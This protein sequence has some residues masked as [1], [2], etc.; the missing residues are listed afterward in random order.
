MKESIAVDQ[1]RSVDYH[2][3]CGR[4]SDQGLQLSA[5]EHMRTAAGHPVALL[6]MPDTATA[7]FGARH[8]VGHTGL[9]A[10]R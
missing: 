8:T 3:R 10:V 1:R 2:C 7:S 6:H 5:R 9:E 4:V